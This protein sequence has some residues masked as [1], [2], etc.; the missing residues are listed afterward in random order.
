MVSEAE[1]DAARELAP[2][3]R[4]RY[5]PNVVDVAAIAPVQPQRSQQRLLFVASF[6]YE[7][8][9]NGM[10]F[11]VDEVLP[12]VWE[13]LPQAR[14]RL[15]GAGLEE[16]PSAD[17]RVEAVGFVAD[18]REAYAASSCA[19]VPL[20]QGGGTPLKFIEALA[21]GLPVVATPRAAAGLAV[22]D[23]VDCLL[24]DGAERFAAAVVA[25]LRDGGD[26][27]ARNG[28]ELAVERYSIEALT[29]LL[30]DA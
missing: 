21:Y 13:Q 5:V 6:S 18:L 27:L 20:L 30:A 17:A 22:R 1:L 10:R 2:D 24:A 15:V 28:R 3:A 7:P 14:L 12:R 16:P 26:A 19:I 25:V 9:R 4:L 29:R 23:G 8:N 11:L